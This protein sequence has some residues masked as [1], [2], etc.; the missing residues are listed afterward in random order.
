MRFTARMAIRAV[1]DGS[2]CCIGDKEGP[3]ACASGCT[4]CYVSKDWNCSRIRLRS[5]AF[6]QVF[7]ICIEA[8]ESILAGQHESGAS[9]LPRVFDYPSHQRAGITVMLVCG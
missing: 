5:Y 1:R 3:A 7:E 4:L 8:D 9:G 2:G 6:V